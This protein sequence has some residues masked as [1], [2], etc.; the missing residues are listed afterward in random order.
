MGHGNRNLGL[1]AILNQGQVM[2]AHA[3][4]YLY[5]HYSGNNPDQTQQ[6][7]DLTKNSKAYVVGTMSAYEAISLAW[8]K[9]QA[10]YDQLLA[11][12]GYQYL[13]QAYKNSWDNQFNNTYNQAGSLTANLEFQKQY[14]K[15]FHDAGIP[16]MFGTDSPGIVGQH[17]G[18]SIH[19]EMRT[20]QEAGISN[21]DI[22]KIGTKNFGDFV[23]EYSRYKEDFG[24]VKVGHRADLVLLNSNPYTSLSAFRS[25]IIV[26]VRG[27]VYTRSFLLA[28]L[29]KLA[30]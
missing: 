25:P 7:I 9:N 11:R 1:A 2:I 21:A 10:G 15:Q 18:F 12:N 29:A 19:E 23:K 13:S 17:A 8:G 3:E 27:K 30:N 28:E 26:M 16:L 14:V 5:T 6:A 24:Q 20:L 4:E 22:L